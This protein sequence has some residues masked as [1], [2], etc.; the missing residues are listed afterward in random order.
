MI[1]SARDTILHASIV[2]SLAELESMGHLSAA[3]LYFQN[4]MLSLVA[5]SLW[6]QTSVSLG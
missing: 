5:D 2:A 3:F 1:E 6:T 4:K